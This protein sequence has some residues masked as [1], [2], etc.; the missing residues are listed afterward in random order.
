MEKVFTRQ[1][2]VRYYEADFRGTLRPVTMFDYLQDAASGDSVRTGSSV[3]DLLK[4]NMTWVLSRYHV[5]LIRSPELGE[6]LNVRTWRS[7]IDGHFAL[8]EFEVSDE[9]DNLLA[10]ATSSWAIVNM[11]TKR[12]VKIEKVFPDLSI[13]ERRAL[14]AGFKTLPKLDRWEMEKPFPVRM[15]DLDLNRHVNNAVYAGWALETVPDQILRCCRL[16]EIEIS[17][18]AE[19]FYGDTVTARTGRADSGNTRMFLHQLVNERDGREL[20][21]LKTAWERVE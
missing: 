13:L 14:D 7:G 10:L 11:D 9:R 17:Y 21:R 3:M 18:R 12:P 1:Y 2:R 15:G 5:K 6:S 8:R 16:S 20:T 4:R 19:A